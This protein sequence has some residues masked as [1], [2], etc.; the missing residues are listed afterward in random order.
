MMVLPS[1]YWETH[2]D[3]GCY[4]RDAAPALIGNNRAAAIAVNVIL[5]FT[6][7]WGQLNAQPELVARSMAIFTTYPKLGTNTV[8]RHMSKQF[9]RSCVPIIRAQRQQGMIHIY[10]TLCT[11]GKCAVCP[12]SGGKWR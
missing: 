10:K 12:L 6:Y 1:G 11:Q 9:G 2:Y 4:C 3:F 7:A 8:E 5:P